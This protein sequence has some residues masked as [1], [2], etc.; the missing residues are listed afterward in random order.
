MITQQEDTELTRCRRLIEEKTG[1]GK[2]DGWAT[3]DFERLAEQIASQTGVSLSVTTLKRVWGRVRYDSA[4]TATTLNALVQFIGYANWPHFVSTPPKPTPQPELVCEPA[5]NDPVNTPEAAYP[6]RSFRRIHWPLVVAVL[7]TAVGGLVFLLANSAP[8]PLSSSDF[9]FSSRPITKGIPN[10]VIFRYDAT[11]SPTDSVFIQQSWDPSRRQLVS[12]NGH[13]HTSIYYHPG[14]FRAKLVVGNQ[15]VQEHNLLI[16]SDGWH[17]AVMQEPVPV[18]FRA[19]EVIRNGEL[20]LPV[21]VIEQQHI[22]MQPQPPAVRYRYVKAFANLRADNFILETRVR[23]TFRQGSSAC[24]RTVIAILC[25]NEFFAIPLS[26]NGCVGDLNLYLAGHVARSANTDLSGFGA[27]LSEW[28][29]VRCVV[30]NKRATVFVNG[31]KAY[32]AIALNAATGIV[33][34]S[35]EFD[36]SGSV[37]F[38]R[39]RQLNGTTVFA[40]DFG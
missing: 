18:Y 31:K 8:K 35:Y 9:S 26:A 3:Q 25:K 6:V 30:Q 2:S 10:S 11:A 5:H 34:I 23:N 15:I 13:E 27:D 22:P 20:H 24:Q 40:D 7:V 38:V 32:Q 37:D 4:P 33:G 1:W 21:A 17:V 12:K 36:G 28:V 39:F 16:P 29:D 14:S 19:D